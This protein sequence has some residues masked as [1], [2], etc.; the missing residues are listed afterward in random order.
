MTE[1]SRDSSLELARWIA[2]TLDRKGAQDVVVLETRDYS[3]VADFFVIATGTSNRHMETLLESPCK[4]L[5]ASGHPPQS[6]EGESTHW[7]LADLGDV[8]LHIFD[9]QARQYFELEHLWKK[10]PRIDWAKKAALRMT[11]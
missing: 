4:E 5:K 6:I 7:M 10:A 3:S 2:Q 9:D 8:V 11:T 1:Q